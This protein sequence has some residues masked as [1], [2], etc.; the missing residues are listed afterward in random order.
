MQPSFYPRLVLTVFLL[1]STFGEETDWLSDHPVFHW[2]SPNEW[3]LS[4]LLPSTSLALSQNEE[5]RLSGNVE[6][7]LKNE[8]EC[9]RR[10]RTRTRR[11]F[12]RLF[13]SL[14][15]LFCRLPPLSFSLYFPLSFFTLTLTHTPTLSLSLWILQQNVPTGHL[16]LESEGWVSYLLFTCYT[17]WTFP[18]KAVRIVRTLRLLP[19]SKLFFEIIHPKHK[20][21]FIFVLF[22]FCST[23]GR[24][25][26]F[27]ISFLSRY[28]LKLKK[29]WNFQ[30]TVSSAKGSTI[31]L[32]PLYVYLMQQRRQ[33]NSSQ[34]SPT[35]F[36]LDCVKLCIAIPS[37]VLAH[38]FTMIALNEM[39][40]GC[41]P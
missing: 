12:M 23:F 33:Q 5:G 31:S 35:N 6:R 22:I 40:K 30:K 39:G 11:A 38:F 16:E 41:E 9:E 14:V 15:C 7:G 8:L 20:V 26:D 34:I 13:R 28:S 21:Q 3:S 18:S 19:F 37:L 25:L 36:K 27:Q 4:L 2:P 29:V 10:R 1:P 24:L 17:P 32:H